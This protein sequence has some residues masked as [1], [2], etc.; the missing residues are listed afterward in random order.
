MLINAAVRAGHTLGN[1]VRWASMLRSVPSL[2]R[3]YSELN[4]A[5]A[6]STA[7]APESVLGSLGIWCHGFLC[8]DALL[9]NPRMMITARRHLR[10]EAC[11]RAIEGETIVVHPPL[12]FV[13]HFVDLHEDAW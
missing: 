13:T 9:P 1:A 7:S 2:S 4:P 6:E 10:G 11:K 8:P 5:Y 3:G 12:L